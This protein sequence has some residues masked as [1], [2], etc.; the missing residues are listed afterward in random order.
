MS[1][2]R[3]DTP[4]GASER[5]TNLDPKQHSGW[6][7]SGDPG[8]VPATYPSGQD[9][10]EGHPVTLKLSN[11]YYST[12]SVYGNLIQYCV[13]NNHSRSLFASFVWANIMTSPKKAAIIA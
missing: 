6:S 9:S 7:L 10:A 8:V 2:L 1:F 3:A 5:D 11:N 12:I 4:S 13:Q